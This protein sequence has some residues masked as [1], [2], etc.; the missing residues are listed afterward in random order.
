MKYP[1]YTFFYAG[2]IFIILILKKVHL[3]FESSGFLILRIILIDQFFGKLIK[4]LYSYMTLQNF[5]KKLQPSHTKKTSLIQGKYH[6]YLQQV[7]HWI[8]S[9]IINEIE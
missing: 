5:A 4:F 6:P 7:F 3:I 1:N 8:E 2:A 9:F